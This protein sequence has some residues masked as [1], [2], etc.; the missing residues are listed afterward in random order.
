MNF[1]IIFRQAYLLTIRNPLL[2]LFGVVLLGGFNLSLVNFAAL[3]QNHAWKTWPLP[4]H[5]LSRTEPQ[6]I[7]IVVTTL[8]IGFIALHFIKLTFIVFAHNLIH[9]VNVLGGNTGNDASK[10]NIHCRLCVHVQDSTTPLLVWWIRIMIASVIT[11][12]ITAGISI[13]VNSLLSRASGNI[14][15]ALAINLLFLIIVTCIVG[16]WNAFTTYFIVLHGQ[17]FKSAI[18]L[19]FD[20]LVMHFRRVLEFVVC[21]SAF[22]TVAVFVGNAFISVWQHGLTGNM[23]V[24]V[25]GIFLVLF[26]LWMAINNT[27]FNIAFLLFFDEIVKSK[28]EP[29]L[30]TVSSTF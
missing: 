2:W 7:A 19:A 14:E 18:A 1:R 15:A 24:E 6:Q 25:R 5:L 28:K 29:L 12:A 17:G 20:L 16:T 27:F 23:S 9:K 8:V 13:V 30:E 11:I 22:Y 3:V 4:L 21:L 26:V 10:K